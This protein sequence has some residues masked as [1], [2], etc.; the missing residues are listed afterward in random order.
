MVIGLA[1]TIVCLPITQC[2]EQRLRRDTRELGFVTSNFPSISAT[3]KGLNPR[4]WAKF[5]R[6]RLIARILNGTAEQ[7]HQSLYSTVMPGLAIIDQNRMTRLG[8]SCTPLPDD[9][10]HICLLTRQ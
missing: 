8:S 10:W 3:G 7:Q 4:P 1:I 9:L 6:Q 5:H 2:F